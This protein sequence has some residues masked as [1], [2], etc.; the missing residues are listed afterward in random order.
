[1][2]EI[3]KKIVAKM[4]RSI[5]EQLEAFDAS[6]EAGFISRFCLPEACARAAALA[7]GHTIEWYSG[8]A[9]TQKKEAPVS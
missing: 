8:H 6:S 3:D 4:A 7:M 5:E 9:Y 1:M 2:S